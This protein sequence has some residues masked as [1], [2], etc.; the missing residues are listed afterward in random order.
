MTNPNE[1]GKNRQGSSG[2]PGTKFMERPGSKSDAGKDQGQFDDEGL[3][4]QQEA[5]GEGQTAKEEPKGDTWKYATPSQQDPSKKSDQDKGQSGR[6]PN[7]G[8]QKQQGDQGGG[9]QSTG[10]E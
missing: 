1:K 6:N 7:K 8:G 2:R 5:G 9:Q 4:D 3:I 10:K